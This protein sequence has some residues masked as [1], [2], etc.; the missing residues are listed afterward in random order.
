[1]SYKLLYKEKAFKKFKLEGWYPSYE[2][3]EHIIT[4][5]KKRK[6]IRYNSDGKENKAI[7][8]AEWKIFPITRHEAVQAQKDVPF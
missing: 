5:Y 4:L 1:M 3:A 7:R 6:I 8:K 2:M